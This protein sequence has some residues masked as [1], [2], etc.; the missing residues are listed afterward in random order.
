MKVQSLTIRGYKSLRALEEFQLRN[1]NIIVGANGAG[2]SNF[3]SFFKFASALAKGNLQTYVQAQGGPDALLYGTRKTTPC[4]DLKIVFQSNLNVFYNASL[5]PTVDNRLIFFRERAK[6][7]TS[8]FSSHTSDE[9]LESLR[10]EYGSPIQAPSSHVAGGHSE[11]VLSEEDDDE[12]IADFRAALQSWKQYHFQDT[13][14]S[15]A[16]KRPQSSSDNLVLKAAA[17]NL[18]PYLLRLRLD[19]PD[20][21]QRI[22]DTIKLAAPFFG[23]F[24]MRKPVPENIQ[25]EWFEQRDPD[26]PYKAHVLS[27]GT[28]RFICLATLLMQPP[29]LLPDA[30]LLDEPELGLHPYAINLL[31]DMLKQVAEEKQVLVATQSVELLNCFKPE[32]VVVAERQDD[33]TVLKRLDT[34]ELK[35]WLEDYSLGELWKRNIF[36][37]RPA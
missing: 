5:M 30:V 4:L 19:Y 35:D 20:Y 15:A 33:A 3:L 6:I 23:G 13:S 29:E 21:Y 31:A 7:Y 1:L 12:S 27:D 16:V 11:S 18:A 28:L 32:D 34:E 26:T 22:I 8:G 14:D 17:D 36:G 10:Q 2:K 25:L 9:H 24:V 37:G